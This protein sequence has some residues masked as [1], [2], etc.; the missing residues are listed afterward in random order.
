M[1]KFFCIGVS[2]LTRSWLL[3]G[4]VVAAAACAVAADLPATSTYKAPGAPV[5][6][7]SWNGLYLGGHIGGAWDQRNVENFNT[8]TGAPVGPGSTNAS[9]IMGGGQVGYNYMVVPNWVVGV[10]AD[11]S[12]AN[13]HSTV[14]AQ[15]PR[16]TPA[17]QG[18]S[19][20][21]LFGTVRGR[22]GYAWNN[23]LLYGTGGFA[24]AEEDRTR[25][26]LAGTT[27]NA[28]PG[29]VEST[30]ATGTGWTAGG[31][32]EWSI[33]QNWTARIEYLHLDLGTISTTDPIAERRHDVSLT[34]DAV[35]A[36][37][38]YRF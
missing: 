12:G 4:S 2:V 13:L 31:G 34:V 3:A 14:V 23:L 20:V 29:T 33:V 24:W 19:R 10:E 1:N 26:Q 16:G 36:G 9:G 27:G 28:T 22:V 32:I 18:D 5:P 8:V 35:R 25:T 15:A 11:V 37:V 17:V 38:N 7:Y 6:N 30:S 21:D